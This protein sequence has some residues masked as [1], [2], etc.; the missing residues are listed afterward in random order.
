[1]LNDYIDEYEET[2]DNNSEGPN[3]S[4]GATPVDLQFP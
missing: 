4:S 3:V 2:S 1:M